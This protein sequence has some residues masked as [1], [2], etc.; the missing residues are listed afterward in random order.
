MSGWHLGKSLIDRTVTGLLMVCLAAC[1]HASQTVTN[2]APRHVILLIGDGMGAMQAEAAQRVLASAPGKGLT[3]LDFP[4]IGWQRT[5]SA[6]HEITD[7]AAAA[8]ALACGVRTDNGK[9]GV[10]SEGRAVTS[11]AVRA[12][13][14]DWK[15]ALLTSVSIDHATPAAFYAHVTNRSGYSALARQ[16]SDAPLDFVG[17]GGMAGQQAATSNCPDNLQR[18]ISNGYFI[19]RTREQ[20]ERLPPGKRIFAFNH[21]LSGSASLPPALLTDSDDIRLAEF[22]AAALRHLGESPLFMMVEGGQI[23]WASHDHDLGAAVREVEAFDET[24]RVCLAFARRHPDTLIVVT[25]DHETGGLE[26]LGDHA[27]TPS[28]LLNQKAPVNELRSRLDALARDKAPWRAVLPV[29]HAVCGANTFTAAQT[30]AQEQ[31]WDGTGAGVAGL[32]K[33]IRDQLA[34]QTGYRFT[35]GGHTSAD[36]PVYAYGAGAEVFAGDY[37]NTGIFERLRRAMQLPEEE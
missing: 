33:L 10:T 30:A 19:V 7:S 6:S 28:L 24:V 23:D 5:R 26:R 36:V 22:A 11:I 18:A 13:S 9:L 34:A 35:T 32:G 3:F 15:V 25:G 37:D 29:V 14:H 20:L 17:G 8:T 2:I 16:L 21:T 12:Q 31:A 1:L 4:V 27:G